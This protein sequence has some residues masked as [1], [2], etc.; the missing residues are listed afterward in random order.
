MYHNLSIVLLNTQSVSIFFFT[1]YR[2]RNKHSCVFLFV[3]GM[4][5]SLGYIRLELLSHKM[6]APLTT[7]FHH[8]AFQSSC[9]NSYPYHG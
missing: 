8:I 7:K 4:R 2:Y 6:W 1:N 3:Y 5:I 9:A